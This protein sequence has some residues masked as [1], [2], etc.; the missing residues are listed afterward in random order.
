[1]TRKK[2]H[3]HKQNFGTHPVPEQSRKF[4]YVYVFFLSLIYGAFHF[5]A[6]LLEGPLQR[7]AYELQGKFAWANGPF[8]LFSG[9][10]IWTNG[11]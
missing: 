4:V 1:M 10:V 3:T 8:A 7:R 2:K 5:W 6:R 9:K 11:P